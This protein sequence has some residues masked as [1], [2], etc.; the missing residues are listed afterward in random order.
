MN[1]KEPLIS[2]GKFIAFGTAYIVITWVIEQISDYKV[3]G[4]LSSNPEGLTGA[5]KH[6]VYWLILQSL[7]FFYCVHKLEDQITDLKCEIRTLEEKL[8]KIERNKR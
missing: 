2:V 4:E 6:I 1:I 5:I 8:E 3:E 7:V